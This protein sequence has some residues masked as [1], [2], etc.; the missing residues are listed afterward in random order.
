MVL[1][2]TA[3]YPEG[4]GQVADHGIIKHSRGEARVVDVQR[5]GPVIVHV[6]EGEPP[7]ESETVE[8]I[9][10]SARR[11]DLMRMHTATHILLQS[12]R[13]V[14]GRHV[15]QAGA[16]KNVPF[17]RLDVTHYKLPSRDEIRKI[18]ELA[19]QMVVATTQ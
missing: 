9:V 6:I 8:G 17:S 12:I 7:M 16:E 13:R 5:V 4:G 11:L 1:D 15:W 14:L 2:Q 18:E 19:N 10:D 3:F